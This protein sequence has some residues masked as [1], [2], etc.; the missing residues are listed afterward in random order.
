MQ[1]LIN[2]FNEI[3]GVSFVSI[4]YTNAQNELQH[5]VFNVGT[6]Y[7]TAKQKDYEYLKQFNISEHNSYP[8]ELL[9]EALDSLISD[10][11]KPSKPRMDNFIHLNNGLKMHQ[12]THELYVYGM[13]ISKK[14][15]VE[16]EYK[17]DTRKPL[18]KAKDYIRSFLRTSKFRQYKI[19]RAECFTVK[20]DTLV[21]E[22]VDAI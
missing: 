2:K 3:K 10:F 4:V 11:E 8:Q 19:E 21:F 5:T 9:Q 12:E 18:T 22:T 20:G 7:A 13:E 16:G 1:E 15:L 17:E 6:N 14:V